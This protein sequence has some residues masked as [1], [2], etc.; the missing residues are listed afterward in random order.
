[1]ILTPEFIGGVI[2]EMRARAACLFK[3][4]RRETTLPLAYKAE[5]EAMQ[6]VNSAERWERVIERLAFLEPR[7]SPTASRPTTRP[8][9][10]ISRQSKSRTAARKPVA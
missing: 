2:R 4:A 7:V 1:M 10:A 6:L 8:P 3:N 9:R 5:H